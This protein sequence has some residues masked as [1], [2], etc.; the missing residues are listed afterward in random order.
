MDGN[1]RLTPELSLCPELAKGL[2]HRAECPWGSPTAYTS[3]FCPSSVQSPIVAGWNV[4]AVSILAAVTCVKQMSSYAVLW[5]SS[6][7]CHAGIQELRA[8]SCQGQLEFRICKLP[9]HPWQGQTSFQR[10]D[11]SPSSHCELVY[12][13][14]NLP[15]VEPQDFSCGSTLPKLTEPLTLGGHPSAGPIDTSSIPERGENFVWLVT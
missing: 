3:A 1:S 12:G 6:L 14:M 15:R 11:F 4:S 7:Q 10:H 9:P 8:F 13:E 2:D 5:P